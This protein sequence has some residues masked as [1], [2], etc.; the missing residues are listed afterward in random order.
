VENCWFL[1]PTRVSAA[2][3]TP[4]T[5]PVLG[6]N[7]FLSAKRKGMISYGHWPSA[8]ERPSRPWLAAARIYGAR[9]NSCGS[10]WESLAIV[11]GSVSIKRTK[12]GG[13]SRR[14]FARAA[15]MP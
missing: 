5:S 13:A 3:V 6:A 11:A 2:V 10:G 1:N 12:R 4:R 7:F 9:V 14:N 15:Q 8:I